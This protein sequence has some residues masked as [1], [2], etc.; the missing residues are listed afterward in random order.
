MR[1]PVS[2]II[3]ADNSCARI[4]ARGKQ[5]TR[6]LEIADL[7]HPAG[8][9]TQVAQHDSDRPGRSYDSA[10]KGRHA[11]EPRTSRK[12]KESALFAKQIAEFTELHKAEFDDLII[13]CAPG[14]LGLLRKQMDKSVTAKIAREIRKDIAHMDVDSIRDTVYGKKVK[15]GQTG[16]T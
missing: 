3:V 11:M 2:W 15:A 13:V 5:Q 1:M 4:F 6:L 10:G 16:A 7:S 14:L 8:R 9:M 12:Q